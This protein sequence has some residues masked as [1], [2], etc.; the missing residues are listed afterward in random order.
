[1]ALD[2][3]R[4]IAQIR[5]R[6]DNWLALALENIQNNANEVVPTPAPQSIPSPIISGGG[7]TA[8]TPPPLHLPTYYPFLQIGDMEAVNTPWSDIRS[9]G[10]PLCGAGLQAYHAAMPANS[11]TVYLYSAGNLGDDQFDVNKHKGFSLL[12]SGQSGSDLPSLYTSISSVTSATQAV[13]ATAAPAGGLSGG[14]VTATVSAGGSGYAVNDVL[15]V[16]G[17]GGNCTLTVTSVSSGAVTGF[18][19]SAEGTGYIGSTNPLSVTGGHGTGCTINVTAYNYSAEAYWWPSGQDDTL[20][21]QSAISSGN[22]RV[23]MPAGV[24]ILNSG[25]PVTYSP[26]LRELFGDG[27]QKTVLLAPND[28]VQTF[29]HFTDV[30][31]LSIHDFST[32]GPG[33]DGAFGGDWDFDLNIYSNI[34]R[35][36]LWNLEIKHSASAHALYLNTPIIS[37][38]RNVKII[39]NAGIGL[40]LFDPVSCNV[41]DCYI[42]TNFAANLL[43]QQGYATSVR[44][45]AF[46]ACGIHAIL[47]DCYGVT[48]TSCDSEQPSHQAPTAPSAAPTLAAASGGSI[49]VASYSVGFTWYRQAIAGISIPL[50]SME[51]PTANVSTTSG[52]QTVNITVP[53]APT[54]VPF[55]TQFYAYLNNGTT[56]YKCG[57]FTIP[58][59][60]GTVGITSL[61]SAANPPLFSAIGHHVIV[62]GG[63]NNSIEQGT[64]N[65]VPVAAARFVW[66]L[67]DSSGVA[68]SGIGIYRP[69]ILNNST[70]TY[71]IE[72]DAGNEIVLD[73]AL[74]AS[75]ITGTATRQQ[76]ATPQ[77]AINEPLALNPPLSVTS[78][79]T[80]ATTLTA[81]G[82]L[83]GEGTAAVGATAAG[84]TESVLVGNG[85]S[86][87]PSFTGSPTLSGNVTLDCT[88]S[89][90]SSPR[91]YTFGNNGAGTSYGVQF[92]GSSFFRETYADNMQITE[93]WGIQLDG[94]N[95]GTVPSP[96]AGT[97]ST[98]AVSISFGK[99]PVALQLPYDTFATAGSSIAIGT[100]PTAGV[101]GAIWINTG[102]N[103]NWPVVISNGT[104]NLFYVTNTG[105]E[106]AVSNNVISDATLKNVTSNVTNV[107]PKLAA[108][109]AINFTWK[110]SVLNDPATHIGML[111]QDVAAQFPEIAPTIKGIAGI[112]QGAMIAVLV[113]AVNELQAEIK[114]LQA[115]VGIVL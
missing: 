74:A 52:N 24:Y 90:Q 8:I 42:L 35:V 71:D 43:I 6:G 84:A 32:R 37:S 1:M 10:T 97:T 66:L 5:A 39:Y 82:V 99:A 12:V 93:F 56:T 76:D 38:F 75:R 11:T 9:Y 54:D 86:T 70:A 113:Q 78:G 55:V 25:L 100:A 26:T 17:G 18:S 48:L 23:Y 89:S 14:I 44:G 80:G 85:P 101:V 87:D 114:A 105:A 102:G 45:C 108:L 64:F 57:P 62:Q 72:I 103:G 19:V 104:S 110:P 73:T 50:E 2:I 13:A 63:A 47:Q 30:H 20:A 106:F 29:F 79:G 77:L 41:D 7:G 107:L 109:Q 22:P 111:A 95:Q 51:S 31:D 58:S 69:N 33:Q 34:E 98:P 28:N 53:A 3:S 65:T 61:G 16:S 21:L 83:L 60:G 36:R 67:K 88:G 96:A 81:H 15:T 49:P 4:H 40:Q 94:M 68:P 46:E 27:T 59:G 91:V 92:S 115:K 112:D